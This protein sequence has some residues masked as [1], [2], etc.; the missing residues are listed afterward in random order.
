MTG[1]CDIRMSSQMMYQQAALVM[2]AAPAPGIGATWHAP[3][4]SVWLTWL[5]CVPLCLLL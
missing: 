4:T 1:R 2:P 5:Q 3:L